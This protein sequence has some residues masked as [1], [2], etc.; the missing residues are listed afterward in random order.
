MYCIVLSSIKH[1]PHVN[2]TKSS[3]YAKSYPYHNYTV[4]SYPT[5]IILYTYINR[6]A[7]TPKP[8]QL[9]F[10]RTTWTAWPPRFCDTFD[11]C[12]YHISVILGRKLLFPKLPVFSVV[13]LRF[14]NTAPNISHGVKNV[15]L[16]F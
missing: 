5:G 7:G 6:H 2:Q 4:H 10:V 15:H 1:V 8:G 16:W 12:L 3:F 14:I 11:T 13:V 9:S